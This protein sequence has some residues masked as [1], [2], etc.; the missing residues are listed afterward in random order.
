MY[1]IVADNDDFFLKLSKNRHRREQYPDSKY[2][3]TDID[4]VMKQSTSTTN[5][6]YGPTNNSAAS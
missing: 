4:I 5:N 6:W 1:Q 2:E 3:V